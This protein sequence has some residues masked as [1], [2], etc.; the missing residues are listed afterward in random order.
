MPRR[1]RIA[2]GGMT[3]HTLNRGVDR[4]QI[5]FSPRDFAAF[6]ETIQETLLL[7][8]MRI[9][10]YTLMPNHWHLVLWP[11]GDGELSSFLQRLT[12]TH[13]QRWQLARRKVGVGHLYQGRFK[14]FPVET[15]EYHYS[16]LRYVE[17]NP[18]RA[19]L[20]DRAEHWRWG[21]LWRRLHGRN[22]SLLTPW[23]LPERD[24]WLEY[25]NQPQNEREVAAIRRSI[26]RGCP[27]GTDTWVRATAKALKL[28][29]TL[30]P[31]GRPPTKRKLLSRRAPQRRSPHESS[32]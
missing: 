4:R 6:E 9:L 27:W 7:Y 22:D 20:V 24:S 13:T 12:N 25:V 31:R 15:D 23:P 8:P 3:F 10:D 17:R 5:F 26:V 29:S 1:K 19:N 18:L 2:P 16:V 30:R 21:S 14:S 32:D 28:E 11:E